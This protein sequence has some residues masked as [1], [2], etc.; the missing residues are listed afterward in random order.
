MRIWIGCGALRSAI[1]SA[2]RLG[3]VHTGRFIKARKRDRRLSP[4][5]PR[6]VAG[7]GRRAHD[8]LV[9]GLPEV[10]VAIRREVRHSIV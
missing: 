8:V 3:G 5:R 10:G 9:P 6:A 2:T 4:R 7:A 1:R